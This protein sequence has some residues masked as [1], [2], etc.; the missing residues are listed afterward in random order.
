MINAN[1]TVTDTDRGMNALFRRLRQSVSEVKI[2]VHSDESETLLIIAAA[3]EYGATI[4]HPGGTAYGFK[5]SKDAKAGKTR[6]LK[7]GK[8]F[9][10]VGKTDPHIITIPARS[11][12]RSTVDTNRE[13]YDKKLNELL[14]RV[15][16]GNLTSF[17]A[18]EQLGMLVESDIKRKMTTLRTPPN[19]ASTIRKKKSDNPLIDTG[20]LRNSIRYVVS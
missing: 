14:G 2:G 18:L 3:N 17:D 5:T 8:G 9:K 7:G 19:A 6:F 20:H 13:Q 11:Y 15:V 12:I 1:V 4:H 10:V 16:D